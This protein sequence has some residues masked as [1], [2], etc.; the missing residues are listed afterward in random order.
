MVDLFIDCVIFEKLF[1][2]FVGVDCF[3]LFVVW[4]GRSFVKRYG[5]LFICLFIRVIYLEVVYSF[6]IDLFINVM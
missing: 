3:G 2:M 5:V 4:R 1:F 6:D